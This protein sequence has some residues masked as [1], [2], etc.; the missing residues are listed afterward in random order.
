MKKL[1]YVLMFLQLFVFV[2]A[3][4]KK[5]FFDSKCQIIGIS[6]DVSGLL[7]DRSDSQ[8]FLNDVIMDRPLS[9]HDKI[10]RK[11]ERNYILQRWNSQNV[12]KKFL[13]YLF[14]YNGQCLS[15]DMLKERA[16]K[17][18]K[19]IDKE[20]ASVGL[21][22]GTAILQEDYLPILENNYIV[23][24][25]E[26]EKKCYWIVYKVD[27]DKSILN[28]VFNSWD[29]M[30]RY[31]AIKVPIVY[32]ASGSF[33][34]KKGNLARDISKKVEA[35]AIRGQIIDNF[36][37]KMDIGTNEGIK[38]GDRIAVYRQSENGKGELKSKRIAFARAAKV[39]E[40]ETRMFG[41]SGKPSSYKKGDIGVL[42]RDR[43][44][45][46]SIT[47]DFI[48]IKDYNKYLGINYNL[49]YRVGYSKSGI[50]T[51]VLSSLGVYGADGPN[52]LPSN[53]TIYNEAE[54]TDTLTYVDFG[55]GIGFGK[56]IFKRI[57]IMPYIKT[58]FMFSWDEKENYDTF[59]CM[60]RIPV[61]I[62][63]NIN[64]FY[65]LQ[66]FCGAEYS[67]YTR[68]YAKDSPK[69]DTKGYSYRYDNHI[70]EKTRKSDM[71]KA[72][73]FHAG[74]RIVF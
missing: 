22:H 16:L 74:L 14:M 73:G 68:E 39:T 56:T 46:Q 64:L 53:L 69:D 15:D 35:F 49:D 41:L 43:G 17:N 25:R 59:N 70:D 29:N 51:Y 23:M 42:S 10:Y 71:L 20:R 34:I 1:F 61:G 48:N 33:K 24:T 8:F 13:D 57:E 50:S 32:V 3:N 26:S 72:F 67:L 44:F 30:D 55:F 12:G 62:R 31:N 63:A 37:F 47:G 5:K 2:D 58:H 6:G 27:I 40:S 28:E 4:A 7:N 18:V 52:K 21:I 36:P 38:K 60:I 11:A 9:G 65:P 54:Q 45:A 19:L 66:L